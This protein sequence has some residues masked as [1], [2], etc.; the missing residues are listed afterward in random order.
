MGSHGNVGCLSAQEFTLLLN[1]DVVSDIRS[2][3]APAVSDGV[4]TDTQLQALLRY[5]PQEL[6]GGLIIAPI[7]EPVVDTE[8]PRFVRGFHDILITVGIIVLIIGLSGLASWL[9]ALPAI[10]VL[11]EILVRRQ[12]LALPA[13]VLTVMFIFYSSTLASFLVPEVFAIYSEQ[14]GE[15]ILAL[16]CITVVVA[17]TCIYYLRY[18]VPLA[19]AAIYLLATS[20]AVVL[21][22]SVVPAIF[23]IPSL[24]ESHPLLTALIGFLAAVFIFTVAIRYDLS[25]RLR[26][27]RRSDV[28]F[29]LHLVTAPALLYSALNLIVVLSGNN[30]LEEGFF[31]QDFHPYAVTFIVTCLTLLGIII[32]RRAFVTSGIASIIAAIIALLSYS[33][34]EFHQAFYVAMLAVGVIVVTIGVGW[35]KL[36]RLLLSRLPASFAEKFPPAI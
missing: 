11:A 10:I 25:D 34:I 23:G 22:G 27:T 20:F 8:T 13:I 6:G 1:G 17:L 18:R 31:T 26:V 7:A 36:R 5:I 33:N 32:D 2:H 4:I 3:L 9:F 29:W 28:A 15:P 16:A 24:V 21:V 30:M 35:Q 12:R 19:L 14:F